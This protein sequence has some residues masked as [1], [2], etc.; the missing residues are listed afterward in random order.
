MS[1][2]FLIILPGNA[3]KYMAKFAAEGLILISDHPCHAKLPV[4]CIITPCPGRA[5]GSIE[6]KGFHP[7]FCFLALAAD[8]DSPVLFPRLESLGPPLSR[9]KR[10]E[11]IFPSLPTIESTILQAATPASKYQLEKSHTEGT[12]CQM[13][14]ERRFE[15]R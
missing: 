8:L 4:S 5:P 14:K 15:Q 1:E 9:Q 2:T 13:E 11:R 12:C 10:L 7:E 6:A 3:G